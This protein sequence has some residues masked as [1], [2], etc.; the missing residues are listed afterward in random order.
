MAAEY[1]QDFNLSQ[2]PEI[3]DDDEDYGE[4]D[5]QFLKVFNSFALDYHYHDSF[6]R[7]DMKYIGVEPWQKVK[8]KVLHI[9]PKVLKITLN[10]K[11]FYVLATQKTPDCHPTESSYHILFNTI[12]ELNDFIYCMSDK[13]HARAFCNARGTNKRFLILEFFGN[14]M[15]ETE[16]DQFDGI[17]HPNQIKA[18]KQM[19]A[20]KSGK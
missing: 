17:I 1:S 3:T 20:L 13:F 2:D 6:G 18:E 8:L 11:V 10:R 4:Y 5:D 19:I 16:I 15:T 14:P 12:K 9:L 7:L